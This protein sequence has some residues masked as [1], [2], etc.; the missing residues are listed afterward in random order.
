MN[1]GVIREQLHQQID[2]LP[3]DVVKQIADFTSAVSRFFRKDDKVEYSLEDVERNSGEHTAFGMWANHPEANEPAVFA[4]KLRRQIE[5][6]E[7]A[8]TNTTN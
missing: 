2:D 5:T 3:D 1:N 7:D 6:R 8:T 4:S